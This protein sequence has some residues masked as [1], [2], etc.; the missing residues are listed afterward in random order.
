MPLAAWSVNRHGPAGAHPR[1]H[2]FFPLQHRGLS[3]NPCAPAHVGPW[4]LP[5]AR[6]RV[7]PH[8]HH[9][10]SRGHGLGIGHDW[11]NGWLSCQ[12]SVSF[13]EEP[14]R[15]CGLWVCRLASDGYISRT[16]GPSS[17]PRGS[18]HA[19]RQPERVNVGSLDL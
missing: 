9:E 16:F 3:E 13:L 17:F 18:C 14:V 7:R 6:P 12:A 19:R 5:K 15:S 11:D 10:G 8:R 1:R 4:R 2:R